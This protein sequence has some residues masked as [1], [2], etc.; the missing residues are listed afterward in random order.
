MLI[1][2]VMQQTCET[3][4][5]MAA[6][7]HPHILGSERHVLHVP[8]AGETTR[9]K[10]NAMLTCECYAGWSRLPNVGGHH[11]RA[12]HHAVDHRNAEH[13][14]QVLLLPAGGKL[15]RSLG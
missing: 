13:D 15:R 9:R 10:L 12:S 2:E 8:E 14:L 11:A 4:R 6:R 3:I 7:G 1:E 5:R